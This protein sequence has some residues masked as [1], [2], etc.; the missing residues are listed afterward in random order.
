MDLAFDVA[1]YSLGQL[2][3]IIRETQMKYVVD[4][5]IESLASKD[6]ELRD[7]SGLGPATLSHLLPP[8]R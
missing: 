5:L 3:K 2:I 6:E 1:F 8:V 4:R 7:I